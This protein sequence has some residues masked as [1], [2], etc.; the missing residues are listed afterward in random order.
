MFWKSSVIHGNYVKEMS[1]QEIAER[2]GGEF[3][4]ARGSDDQLHLK[5]SHPYYAQVQGE[6]AITNVE[7]CN[8]VVFSGGKVFVERI[9]FDL[10]YWSELLLPKL[11]SFYVHVAREVLSGRHFVECYHQ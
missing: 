9:W 4:L 6:M 3:R 5:T 1:P 7:W 10:D 11:Q 8:F 2:Y